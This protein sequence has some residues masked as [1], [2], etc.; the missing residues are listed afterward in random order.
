MQKQVYKSGDGT[1]W[2]YRKYKCRFRNQEE[3]ETHQISLG[4]A[5]SLITCQNLICNLQTVATGQEAENSDQESSGK[6]FC[7][8]ICFNQQSSEMIC[9]NKRNFANPTMMIDFFFMYCHHV[10]LLEHC[11]CNPQVSVLIKL[12]CNPCVDGALLQPTCCWELFCNQ[13]ID[14]ALLQSTC[15]CKQARDT[16]E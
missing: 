4:L 6:C 16:K 1:S 13:C 9:K 11:K 7:L 8:S 5:A 15:C 2:A 12:F 3:R 10:S 14:G